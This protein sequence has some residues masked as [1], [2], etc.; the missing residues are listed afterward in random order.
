MS[1]GPKN[2]PRAELVAHAEEAMRRLGGRAQ[3]YFK[4]TC[5][6]CGARCTFEEANTLYEEGECSEC[7]VVSPVHE[8]GY[9]LLASPKPRINPEN[10]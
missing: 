10:N 3:V 5:P 1:D 6:A 2:L 8:G 7:G 4:F 9:L